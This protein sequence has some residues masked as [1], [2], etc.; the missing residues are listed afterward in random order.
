MVPVKYNST[1]IMLLYIFTVCA[2]LINFNR[3]L[4]TIEQR[5]SI[6][7]STVAI[8]LKTSLLINKV[9]PNKVN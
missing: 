7:K 9:H 5:L 1:C 2:C 3:E 4:A 6:N 8:N